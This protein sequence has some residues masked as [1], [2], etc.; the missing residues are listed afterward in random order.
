MEWIF[1][2]R[3]WCS[4]SLLAPSLKDSTWLPLILVQWAENSRTGP[5]EHVILK[6]IQQTWKT[7]FGSFSGWGGGARRKGRGSLLKYPH[8]SESRD[9]PK[10]HPGHVVPILVSWPRVKTVHVV[11]L[12]FHIWLARTGPAFFQNEFANEWMNVLTGLLFLGEPSLHWTWRRIKASF[13]KCWCSP[14]HSMLI[15]F[16]S[17]FY[18]LWNKML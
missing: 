13:E 5:Q 11:K 15:E 18:L 2:P 6:W 7:F 10:S 8:V 9:T 12:T 3:C 17:H 14:K 1:L 16:W 4:S